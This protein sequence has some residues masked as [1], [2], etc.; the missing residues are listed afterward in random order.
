MDYEKMSNA[1]LY[2]LLKA[3]MPAVAK[4]SEKSGIPTEKQLSPF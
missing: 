1:E 2:A 4:P 3:K